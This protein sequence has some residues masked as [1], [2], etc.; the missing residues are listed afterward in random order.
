M[1]IIIGTKSDLEHNR[2]VTTDEGRDLA[3]QL[4]A[5][6]Y[7]IST[8]SQ[9]HDEIVRIFKESADLLRV[10]L[11]RV[12][13]FE[14]TVI[15]IPLIQT[16]LLHRKASNSSLNRVPSFRSSIKCEHDSILS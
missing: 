10:N 2:S 5:R 13:F 1:I 4:N 9:D 12:S 6:Y 11:T 7:E 8:Q 3:H 16:P 15:L 14:F